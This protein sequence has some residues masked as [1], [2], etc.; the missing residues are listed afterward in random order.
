MLYAIDIITPPE[1]HPVDL[2]EAK[3]YLRVDGADEDAMIAGLIAAATQ[4][5]ETVTRRQLVTATLRL[6]LPAFPRDAIHLPRPPAGEVQSVVYIDADGAEQ[7]LDG[8]DYRLANDPQ[9]AALEPAEAWPATQRRRDAVRIT[10]TAGYGAAA[11]VPEAIR[12][13]I[14][15]NVAAMYHQRE[16]QDWS[17]VE[18]ALYAILAPYRAIILETR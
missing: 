18:R 1:E 4:Q 5:A 17:V 15:L 16:G 14:M 8:S 11:D 12:T 10:Y 9:G 3:L 6:A 2:A 7:T 13:A